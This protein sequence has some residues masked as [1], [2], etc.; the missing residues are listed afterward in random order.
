MYRNPETPGSLVKQ[1]EE[2]LVVCIAEEQLSPIVPTIGDVDRITDGQAP[3][4]ARHRAA[5]L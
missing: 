3:L 2:V 4:S 1:L 5:L